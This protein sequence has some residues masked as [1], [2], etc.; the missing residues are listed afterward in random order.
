MKLRRTEV[1]TSVISLSVIVVVLA[2]GFAY[3]YATTEGQKASL[4]SQVSTLNSQVSTLN[5]QVSTLNS[6]VSSL[7]ENYRSFCSSLSAAVSDLTAT[8]TN[9]TQT[10]S[11]RVQ[12]DKSMI[13]TLDSTK[14]AGYEGMIAILNSEITHDQAIINRINSFVSPV[15]PVISSSPNAFCASVSQP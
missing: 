1:G 4:N 2:A 15:G 12:S 3:Y 6:Q 11:E 8:F 7:K 5:S 10:L 14:P 9:I 13:A